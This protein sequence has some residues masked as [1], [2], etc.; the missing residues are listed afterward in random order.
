MVLDK[1]KVAEYGTHVELLDTNGI[2]ARLFN[3]Q[4]KSYIEASATQ[5]SS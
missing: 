2:Y 1:G 4:A 3:L 5:A